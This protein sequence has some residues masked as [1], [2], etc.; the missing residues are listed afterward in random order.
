METVFQYEE[1]GTLWKITVYKNLS[2]ETKTHVEEEIKN[3]LQHFDSL[4]SRFKKTSLIYDLSTKVG[5]FEVPSD[6]IS[7]LR[8]YKEVYELSEKRFTPCIGSL[9]ED[10]GYDSSYS[11][12]EK[13]VKRIV[14]DF[15]EA[16]C[17]LDDT[18]IELKQQVLLD[19]GAVGKGYCVDLIS[20]YL[21]GKGYDHF[22][23]DGSGDIYYASP[24]TTISAGLEHPF[25]TTKVIGVVEMA[26]GAMCS[27]ATNRRAWGKYSH[28]IDP[29]TSESPED[30]VATWV[31]ADNATYA[32]ALSS[33]LFFVPPEALTTFSFQYCIMN[34]E[35]R[36]KKS[37]G[38]LA[39]FF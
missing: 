7:I 11:L 38:F 26:Q 2:E 32:D 8:V 1:M 28:Y 33:L 19:I 22:I 29:Q 39:T 9:L 20:A 3:K 25:D 17:I 18:H 31:M 16:V 34:N 21:R 30:I 35:S 27:S 10:V 14:P 13:E 23:V 36:I 5:M 15:D 24:I 37:P 4:Y 6:L 12:E